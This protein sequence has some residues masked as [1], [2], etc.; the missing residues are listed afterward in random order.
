MAL[1]WENDPVIEQGGMPSVMSP[2]TKQPANLADYIRASEIGGMVRGGLIDPINAMAEM[3]SGMAGQSA[4]V[5]AR[6]REMEQAYQQSRMNMGKEGFDAARMIGSVASP[7]NRLIPAGRGMT[8]TMAGAAAGNV[9]MTPTYGQGD[10]MSEKV[11]QAT[12]GAMAGGAL[13]GVANVVAPPVSEAAQRLMAQGVR[14]TVGQMLGGAANRMEEGAT[15]I[16]LV[17]DVIRGARDY[18]NKTL[19]TTMLNRALKPIGEELP[20]DAPF[21][22]DALDFTQKAFNDAYE[23]VLGNATVKIDPD[24]AQAINNIKSMAASGQM[25]EGTGKQIIALINGQVMKRFDPK[26][27]LAD[28]KNLKEIQTVLGEKIKNFGSSSDANQREVA[29]ALRDVQTALMDMVSRQ[30]PMLR[31]QLGDVNSGYSVFKTVQRAAS[32]VGADEG[33]FT[34]PQLLSAVKAKDASKD[35]ARFAAGRTGLSDI[36]DDAKAVLGN[37]VPDSGTPFRT[38]L[39][40]AGGGGLAAVSPEALLGVLAGTTMYTRPV[41]NA[42]PSLVRRPDA[43]MSLGEMMRNQGQYVVPGLLGD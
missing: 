24:F 42:L 31:K 28:G 7:V 6:N 14:P 37:K 15:S 29:N 26:A 39:G 8:G 25:G 13:R 27:Q 12:E 40:L 34:A 35:K 16:P 2:M 41:Q 21:G 23:R 30:N 33:V 38:M 20:K 22:R 5:G 1:P 36:A 9:L 4:D 18:A 11:R 10:L 17:G 43:V 3:A 32:S 19:N